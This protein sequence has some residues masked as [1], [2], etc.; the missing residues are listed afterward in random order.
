MGDRKTDLLRKMASMRKASPLN[1]EQSATGQQT[2]REKKKGVLSSTFH[3]VQ[4][5]TQGGWIPNL[6]VHD[7]IMYVMAL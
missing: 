1:V 4:C 6:H 3:P 7:A 5:S 2:P